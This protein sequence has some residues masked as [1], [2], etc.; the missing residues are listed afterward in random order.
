[1]KYNYT[2][3]K[4]ADGGAAI[5]MYTDIWEPY[6]DVSVNLSAYGLTP[7]DENHIF[8]PKY[9]FDMDTAD[10]IADDIVEELVEELDIGDFD[11]PCIVWHVRLK[12]NWR[13]MRKDSELW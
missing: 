6:A 7:R 12:E 5:K 3:A 11:R 10:I 4:Y 13:E 9:R 1:M 8:I 2:R